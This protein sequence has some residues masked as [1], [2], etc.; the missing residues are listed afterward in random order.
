TSPSARSDMGMVYDGSD[1]S[2][3]LFGGDYKTA[4][5]GDTWVFT[6]DT[7]TQLNPSS[8]PSPRDLPA[9]VYDAADGYVLLFGGQ[10]VTNGNVLGDTWKFSNGQLTQLSPTTSPLAR[11]DA[12]IAYD[13]ADGYV[14]LFGG[15]S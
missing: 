8:S 11:S 12:S 1:G 9:M 15:E 13:A 3:L 4:N 2:V 6:G 5:L 10:D 14:V 7:W